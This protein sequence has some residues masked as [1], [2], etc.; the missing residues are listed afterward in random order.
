MINIPESYSRVINLKNRTKDTINK[1]KKIESIIEYLQ[2]QESSKQRLFLQDYKINF[3][4]RKKWKKYF[5]K[6]RY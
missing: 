2:K 5:E 3:S 4:V 1:I 6:D